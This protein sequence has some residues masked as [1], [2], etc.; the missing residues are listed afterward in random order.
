MRKLAGLFFLSLLL[1]LSGCAKEY[2][3]E[4]GVTPVIHDTLP[5]PVVVNDFPVCPFCKTITN[6]AL[7]TWSFK[8]GNTT[9]CGT[10]DTAIITLERTA[11]TFFGPSSCSADSGLVITVYL[12]NESLNRNRTNL[13]INNIAFYYYDRVTPSYIF[14][15]LA[16]SPFSGTIDNYDHQTKI[17]SGTFT[18]NAVRSDGSAASITSGKFKVKLL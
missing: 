15:S 13:A 3:Y 16:N 18:G 17:A 6:T 11:F 12:G 5:P 14:M 2:S 8:K 1:I 7:S 4:G 9:V 10:V